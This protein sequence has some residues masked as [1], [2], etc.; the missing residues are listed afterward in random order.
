MPANDERI[1]AASQNQ[2]L[3]LQVSSDQLT[4]VQGIDRFDADLR[5]LRGARTE[6]NWIINFEG[7]TFIVTP[8]VNTL[9][10]LHKHVR[11]GGGALVLTGLNRNIRHVFELMRLD[12]ILE[13]SPDLPSALEQ[14]KAGS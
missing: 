12:Q 11:A 6:K 4:A 14:F 8:V 9:I 1:Q 2:T 7:V 5:E 3:V 10:T 13:I